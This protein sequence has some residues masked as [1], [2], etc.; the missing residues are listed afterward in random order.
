M[1]RVEQSPCT[2]TSG[3]SSTGRRPSAGRVVKAATRSGAASAGAPPHPRLQVLTWRVPL[4]QR[5]ALIAKSRVAL[6]GRDRAG[7]A[8]TTVERQG[9]PR[10]TLRFCSEKLL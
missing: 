8:G 10:R 2:A 9:R 1:L 6:S 3:R 7:A 4:H 5:L